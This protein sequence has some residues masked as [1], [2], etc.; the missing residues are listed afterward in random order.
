MKASLSPQALR[1]PNLA[2]PSALQ[3]LSSLAVPPASTPISQPLIP[4]RRRSSAL[5]ILRR[6]RWLT[7]SIILSALA[8]LWRWLIPSIALSTLPV[9]WRRFAVSIALLWWR[10][11]RIGAALLGR[12][13]LRSR[14]VR[15]AISDSECVV[16]TWQDAC[17][18]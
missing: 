16:I 4:L 2:S 18:C 10:L 15:R 1:L 11:G 3:G 12:W 8:I 17:C 5:A 6:R 13:A 14:R 9:L 7:S